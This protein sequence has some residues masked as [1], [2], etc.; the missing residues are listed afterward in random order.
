MDRRS[1]IS[2]LTLG[3][4]SIPVF[5]SRS[6]AQ[7]VDVDELNNKDISVSGFASES[8][9]SFEENIGKLQGLNGL[10]TLFFQWSEEAF[11]RFVQR[12]NVENLSQATQKTLEGLWLPIVMKPA[13]DWAGYSWET[14][15]YEEVDYER[16]EA[17]NGFAETKDKSAVKYLSTIATENIA[18]DNRERWMA[19]RTLGLIGDTSVV[20]RLIPLIYHYNTNTRLWAQISLVKLT[21]QNFSYDWQA[22]GTWWNAS[23]PDNPFDFTRIDWLYPTDVEEEIKD[24]NS[25]EENHLRIDTEFAKK[26]FQVSWYKSY[27]VLD[28]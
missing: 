9:T 10:Q 11:A 5:S 28:Q 23:N 24:E 8:A 7:L 2:G 27:V 3:F 17:I 12:G 18:K 19:V 1:L 13:R 26:A 25:K 22:W 16:F 21:D 14:F 4:V 15:E 6:F 20:P